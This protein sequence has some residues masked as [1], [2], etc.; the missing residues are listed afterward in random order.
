[1]PLTGDNEFIVID[2]ATDLPKEGQDGVDV[3]KTPEEIERWFAI[4]E[5]WDEYN[6]TGSLDLLR[7]VGII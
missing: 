4:R 2:P 7:E 3:P 5:A 1:M 6:R